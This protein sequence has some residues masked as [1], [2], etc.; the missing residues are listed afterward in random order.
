MIY[1]RTY[2]KLIIQYNLEVLHMFCEKCGC[3]NSE[4][5]VF[6]VNCGTA[7][8]LNVDNDVTQAPP[9]E[10]QYY[11]PQYQ[12][13]APQPVK[14]KMPAL[15][16]GITSMVLGALT[17]SFL[18]YALIIFPCAIIGLIL[19]CMANSRAKAVG[20][21][22]GFAIAGIITSAIGI[23]LVILSLVFFIFLFDSIGST[24][25]YYFI[26]NLPL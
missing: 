24:T 2:D 4:N 17:C 20:L 7:I 22:N 15:G 23:V 10:Q 3:K 19:G 9:Q 21:K 26:N 25:Y 14:P 12:S 16:M 13:P 8:N 6:C 1:A 5:A 11:N 18:C